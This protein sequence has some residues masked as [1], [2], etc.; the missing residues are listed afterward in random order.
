MYVADFVLVTDFSF[1]YENSYEAV[2]ERLIFPSARK[3]N[4]SLKFSSNC[5]WVTSSM[6]INDSVS[7]TDLEIVKSIE[8]FALPPQLSII[9]L[10]TSM[11]GRK[12]T[13][14]SLILYFMLSNSQ[15]DSAFPFLQSHPHLGR[16]VLSNSPG[17]LPFVFLCV[18]FPALF[19][20]QYFLPFKRYVTPFWA[21]RTPAS[22]S[23]STIHPEML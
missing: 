5:Q 19:T 15:E 14:P 10:P 21:H 8:G 11:G 4:A 13:F 20:R 23:L 9:C 22:K 3:R 1:P 16:R 18:V 7:V 17:Y 2:T 6:C 12:W